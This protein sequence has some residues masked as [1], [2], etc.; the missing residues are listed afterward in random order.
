MRSM[1]EWLGET[2]SKAPADYD[3]R[4]PPR[5]R[6][7]VTQKDIDEG[8]PAN[9]RTCA[10]ALAV[11]R[12]LPGLHVSVGVKDVSVFLRDRPVSDWGWAQYDLSDTA[13]LWVQRFDL[14]PSKPCK[15]ARFTLT[16]NDY[17]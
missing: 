7:N 4:F 13:R 14:M 2:V 8:K 5:I 15:P 6:V 12:R 9:H 1:G 11:N 17:P 10:L 16:R 3:E